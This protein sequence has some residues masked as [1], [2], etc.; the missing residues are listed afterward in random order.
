MTTAWHDP[1]VT[2][3]HA[4]RERLAE[5]FRNDLAA[6]SESADAHCRALGFQVAQS[7]MDK[8]H[9]LADV[10]VVPKPVDQA[11]READRTNP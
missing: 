9:G 11:L 5:R 4:V 2:E 10:P 8:D 3:L 1:I 7:P 6:Y